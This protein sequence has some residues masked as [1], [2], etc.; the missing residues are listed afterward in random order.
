M[1]QPTVQ[2]KDALGLTQ[3]INTINPNGPAA[4][5]DAQP[6]VIANDQTV[7]VSIAAPVAIDD[8]TPVDVAIPAPITV[9]T[10]TPLQVAAT[11]DL[12][13]SI[14]APVAVTSAA[15]LVIDDSTPVDVAIPAPITVDTSTPLQVAATADLPVSIAAPVVIDDTT[16]VDVAIPAPITVDTSTPLQVAATADLPVSI[17]APV[18]VDDSTP[19]DVAVPAPIT[20]DTTT[21]L[22]VAVA[23]TVPV[24]IAATVPTSIADGPNL[25]AFSRLRVSSPTLLL[26]V[27]RV[28]DAGV[29]PANLMTSTVVGSGALTADIARDQLTVTGNVFGIARR[30]TKSR[31]V[32][33]PGKS[34]LIFITFQAAVYDTGVAARIGYFDDNDGFFLH[35]TA[36]GALAMGRRAD[37][38]G[39]PSDFTVSQAGWNL[40]KLNGTGPSG[41]TLDVT[42]AQ[43]LVIDMEWL[44]AG[45]VRM[46]FVINGKIYY[47]HEFNHANS[48]ST[49]VYI[50]NPNLTLRWEIQ[51]STSGTAATNTLLAICGQV[52]SEGGYE[53]NGVTASTDMGNTVNAIASGATEEILAIRIKSANRQYA[54]AF[55]QALSVIAASSSNF[56]W[57][58]VVNPTETGAG[59]WSDVATGSSI[60]EKNTTRTVTAGTG[61]VVAS[62]Y[63]A[64][65]VNA[66]HID[67]R[68]VLTLGQTLAGVGDVYSLQVLN[69]GVGSEDYLGSLTWREVY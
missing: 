40:D 44:G 52:S 26:E 9:D 57:R 56:L 23:G 1:P 8:S 49:G 55:V 35:V 43:I 17:A 33:Q 6:V 21:P 62:G 67:E 68:P 38:T 69:L 10:S 53:T 46:G 13:V 42:K 19:I 18:V 32:Y 45:R 58:L 50:G 14:A 66:T 39:S 54:T 12:P 2:V 31:A 30:A 36:G 7:P 4:S 51:S 61:I 47:A 65:A 29:N 11:A 20:V 37:V 25:D 34:L 28:G 59:T 27:K 16:P 22:D 60:M 24:S 48:I 63:V 41:L 15:P 64:S 5:A 3:T